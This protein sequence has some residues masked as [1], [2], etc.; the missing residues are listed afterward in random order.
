MSRFVVGLFFVIGAMSASAA[1]SVEDI[2]QCVQTKQ[3]ER[4][5]GVHS[6]AVV[7]ESMGIGMVEYFERINVEDEKGRIHPFFRPVK[8]GEYDS[9]TIGGETIPAEQF[10]DEYAN[11]M[12]IAAEQMGKGMDEEMSKSGMPTGLLRATGSDPWTSTD[13]RVMLGGG[14][15]MM[16]AAAAQKR[17]ERQNPT[18]HAEGINQMAD[19][20]ATATLVG[21][22]KINGRR[23]YYLT[24]DTENQVQQGD[25]E[26]YELQT[27]H[28]WVDKNWCVPLKFEV[29]GVATST[30]TSP[31]ASR[32]IVIKVD[33]SDYRQVPNSNMF[34]SYLQTTSLQG[35]ITPEQEAQFAESQTQ[36]AE[37]EKQLASMTPQQREALQGM[38]GPQMKMLEG[39]A[40]GGA[41]TMEVKVSE[42]AVNGPPVQLPAKGQGV[43]GLLTAA[44][45]PAQQSAVVDGQPAAAAD[46]ISQAQQAC[47]QRQ[48]EENKKAQETAEKK[49]GFGR[50]LG[51]VSRTAQRVGGGISEGINSSIRSA[52]DANATAQ[53]LSIA[54]KELGLTE[55][56]MEDC[57]NVQ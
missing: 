39:M 51:A 31:P 6:Y 2:M 23:A 53:D 15:E 3:V 17:Q 41:M 46:G 20:A 22:E 29:H 36:L 9:I 5:D 18:D 21:E 50:L 45:M 8:P 55:A 42:I 44:Q 16:R 56:Q 54:A 7:K 37:M 47:L 48:V 33:Y 32:P 49:R 30:N 1:T 10:F 24:A 14:S 28:M 34:E 13:P 25:G 40:N 4:W 38:L 57:R 35:M 11:A 43:M 52:S 12:D 27:A 26:Q 19:F